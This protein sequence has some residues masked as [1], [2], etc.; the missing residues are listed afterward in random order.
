MDYAFDFIKNNGGIDTGDDYPYHA[1]D[2]TCD[3]YRVSN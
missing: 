3:P 2:G 1:Q